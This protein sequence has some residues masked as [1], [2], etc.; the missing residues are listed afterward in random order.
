MHWLIFREPVNAWTHGA[1]AV[2]A[3]P[4]CL[5]LW[6]VC[7]GERVKQWSLLLFGVTLTLCFGGSA[8]YHGVRLPA[9]QI[10]ICRM[11]DHIGIF[12]LIGGSVTP[13]A[14][15]LLD[16]RWQLGTL[17]FVWVMAAFGIFSLL[18]WPT[19]PPWLYTLQ[20]VLIGWG[21]CLGYF[22]MA[23]VLPARALRPVWLGGLLYTV[24]AMVNLAEWPVLVPGVVG[25]H[26]LW[27]V[28]GMAGSFCHFWFMIRWVAPF[29]RR[30][31]I[32]PSPQASLQ[33]CGVAHPA[34]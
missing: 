8:L 22:E 31:C 4:A 27:H 18:L 5:L 7:R 16:G 34:G 24:G 6:R 13:A 9:P 20:Y 21:A 29:D 32:A 19:A 30:P 10:E 3:L 2:A 23:R 28:F 15:V 25:S 14:L 12:L 33:A 17:V 1:W 11:I 26:E